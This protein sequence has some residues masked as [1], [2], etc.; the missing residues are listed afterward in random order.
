MPHSTTIQVRMNQDD[1]KAVQ[2]ILEQMGLDLPTAIRTFLKKVK[3]T[4]SIPFDFKLEPELDENG[5]TPEQVKSILKA[6]DEAK[7]GINVSP[8]FD[9][10][11]DMITYLNSD[12]HED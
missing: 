12:D 7:R 8:T 11:E 9:N 10:V 5:L 3:S 2:N 6:S 4:R 1:K